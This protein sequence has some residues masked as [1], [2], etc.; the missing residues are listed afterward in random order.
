LSEV[1]DTDQAGHRQ[2][3]RDAL[4]CLKNQLKAKAGSS[5]KTQYT[6]KIAPSKQLFAS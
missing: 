1:R 5:K 4:S 6:G 3:S 2:K